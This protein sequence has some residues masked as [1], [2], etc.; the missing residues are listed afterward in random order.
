M[1][2]AT[3]KNGVDV[4][5]TRVKRGLLLCRYS[6]GDIEYTNTYMVPELTDTLTDFIPQLNTR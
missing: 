5:K 3:E 1:L 4:K 2:A 6:D